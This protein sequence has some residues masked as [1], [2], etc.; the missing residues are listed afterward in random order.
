MHL[1]VHELFRVQSMYTMIA[2]YQCMSYK[3]TVIQAL[4]IS[5]TV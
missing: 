5:P 3:P 1:E 2:M 4:S